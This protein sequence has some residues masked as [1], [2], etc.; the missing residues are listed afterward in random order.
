MAKSDDKEFSLLDSLTL[1]LVAWTEER[2][3]SYTE[4]MA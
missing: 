2:P 3:R 1:Q 4:A